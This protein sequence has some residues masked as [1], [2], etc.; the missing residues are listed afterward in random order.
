MKQRGSESQREKK[1]ERRKK[2]K[3][4]KERSPCISRVSF[5]SLF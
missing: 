4:K 3:K 1:R 5:V 2:E